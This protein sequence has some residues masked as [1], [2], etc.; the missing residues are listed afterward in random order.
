MKMYQV[1]QL[2][3]W[4]LFL[5]GVVYVLYLIGQVLKDKKRDSLRR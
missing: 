5:S 4:G 1:M 2:I 3:L